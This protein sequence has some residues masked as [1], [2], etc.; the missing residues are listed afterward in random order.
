MSVRFVTTNVRFAPEDYADLQR[1]AAASGRS[2]A[3]CIRLAVSAYLGRPDGQP[4]EGAAEEILPYGPPGSGTEVAAEVHGETL[5]LKNPLPGVPD[6]DTVWVRC[7]G[8]ADRAVQRHHRQVVADL[9]AEFEAME[10]GPPAPARA[11][12]KE[13]Y[14]P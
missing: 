5:V 9:L 7:I 11:E 4:D 2:L 10:A 6:G 1:L 12:D 13:I 14:D 8:A 3:Q